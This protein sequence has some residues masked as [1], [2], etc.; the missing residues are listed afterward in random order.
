MA[1]KPLGVSLLSPVDSREAVVLK[2]ILQFLQISRP[3]FKEHSLTDSSLCLPQRE[4]IAFYPMTVGPRV[5]D[6]HLHSTNTAVSFRPR[7]AG[8]NASH[9]LSTLGFGTRP[10]SRRLLMKCSLTIRKWCKV[11][12]RDR[13]PWNPTQKTWGCDVSVSG[14]FPSSVSRAICSPSLRYFR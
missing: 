8:H 9:P 13:S 10:E 3:W 2:K 1:L 5:N 14:D 11:S 6:V 4:R 7:R 12:H